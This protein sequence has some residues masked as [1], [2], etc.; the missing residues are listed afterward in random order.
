MWSLGHAV[1]EIERS[2]QRLVIEE[3]AT[4]GA[5][6]LFGA[7]ALVTLL[8]FRSTTGAA[9]CLFFV[10]AGLCA[11]VRSVF[12]ADRT[13]RVLVI[14]RRI[15]FWNFERVYDA[16]AIDRIY[17]RS[18]LKGSGLAVR[19]KSGRRKDL[20]MS[21]GSTIGLEGLACTL[22]YFLSR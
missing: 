7:L 22:N 5:A 4:T 17:V 14:E 21:L 20:T 16:K 10:S 13:R 6:L 3:T 2:H 9:V 11:G 12:I 15:A 8:A 18:T 19:F 1:R